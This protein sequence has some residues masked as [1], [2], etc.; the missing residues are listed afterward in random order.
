MP[1]KTALGM[2]EAQGR[3]R[4]VK[5]LFVSQEGHIEAFYRTT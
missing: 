1:K 5:M 3:V 2:I 4:V